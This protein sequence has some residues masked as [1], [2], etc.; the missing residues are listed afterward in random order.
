MINTH[1][2]KPPP[3][4]PQG[5]DV[6]LLRSWLDGVQL[7]VRSC[8]DAVRAIE[9]RPISHTP[10]DWLGGTSLLFCFQFTKTSATGGTIEEGKCYIKGILT[11]ITSLPSTLSSVTISIKYWVAVDLSA[12][13]A[14]WS[15]GTSY[16]TSTA[17]SEIWPI[18]EIT[19]AS[20][21]IT[22]WKQRQLSDIHTAAGAVATTTQTVA[23]DVQYDTTGHV[24]QKKTI[25]LTIVA[26]GS[27][28]AWTTIT[29]GTAVAET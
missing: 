13:T 5:Q 2:I 16:P 7:S 15:S 23:T 18:L 9:Q 4:I 19:C 1:Q 3:P 28:S 29:G 26:K 14:A 10:R 25:S 22:A 17:T 20:S 8:I 12:N 6:R 21:V 24:V 27:E 11:T